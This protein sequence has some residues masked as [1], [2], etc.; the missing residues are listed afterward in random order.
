MTQEPGRTDNGGEAVLEARIRRGQLQKE[1]EDLSL[2]LTDHGLSVALP[3]P[4]QLV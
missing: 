2:L 4:E 1:L 3:G